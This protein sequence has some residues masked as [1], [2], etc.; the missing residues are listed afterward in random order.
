MARETAN[1]RARKL[2]IEKLLEYRKAL[3]RAKLMGEKTPE[4]PQER[5]S[6][7]LSKSPERSRSLSSSVKDM[8]DVDPGSPSSDDSISYPRLPLNPSTSQS[9]SINNGESLIYIRVRT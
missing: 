8:A 5:S 1:R 7:I 2:H 3:E 6:P 9:D 4:P